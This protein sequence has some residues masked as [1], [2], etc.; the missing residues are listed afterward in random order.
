MERKAVE[1]IVGQKAGARDEETADD[2][3]DPDDDAAGNS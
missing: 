1:I 3:V 2:I